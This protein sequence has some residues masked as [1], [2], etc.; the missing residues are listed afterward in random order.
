MNT[1]ISKE[2]KTIVSRLCDMVGEYMAGMIIANIIDAFNE[3]VEGKPYF[4]LRSLKLTFNDF[5][6][7]EVIDK[8]R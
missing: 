8:K 4:E 7:K 6:E 3:M 5:Y 2:L 1:K